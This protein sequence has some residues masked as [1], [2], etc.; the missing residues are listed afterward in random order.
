MMTLQDK[1]TQLISVAN[2]LEIGFT[3]HESEDVRALAY[4]VTQAVDRLVSLDYALDG[5][6]EE[7]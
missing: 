5:L 3:L 4:M 2:D 7:E 6:E 1:L